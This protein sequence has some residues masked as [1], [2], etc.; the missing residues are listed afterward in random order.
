MMVGKRKRL[1]SYLKTREYTAAYAM[2]GF[3]QWLQENLPDSVRINHI[4][5][6]QLDK[7]I[8]S[9]LEDYYCSHH[10]S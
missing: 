9:F 1:L 5:H 7:Y 10:V 4:P 8:S 6:S 3:I 2:T